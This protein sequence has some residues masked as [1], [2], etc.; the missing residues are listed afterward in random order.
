[1]AVAAAAV[2]GCLAAFCSSLNRRTVLV[3]LAASLDVAN[4][5]SAADGLFGSFFQCEHEVDFGESS[6]EG[7]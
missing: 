6:S 1:V 2:A 4:L 5:R 7:S 3:V